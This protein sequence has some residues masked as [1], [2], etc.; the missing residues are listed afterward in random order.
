MITTRPRYSPTAP[1]NSNNTRIANTQWVKTVLA[2]YA[3]LIDP[4]Q[5]I[6][7]GGILIHNGGVDRLI[8]GVDDSNLFYNGNPIV[9]SGLGA[10]PTFGG[11]SFTGTTNPG[12][13]LKSLST[14][15]ITALGAIGNGSIL[16]NSTTDKLLVRLNGVTENIVT[17]LNGVSPTVPSGGTTGQI[18]SK[19]DSTD[20]N[21]QWVTPTGGGTWGSI[22]GTLSS[23]TDLQAALNS[24]TTQFAITDSKGTNRFNVYSGIGD[25]EGFAQF[26]FAS[27]N[28][29]ESLPQI[30]LDCNAEIGFQLAVGSVSSILCYE[31]QIN[32]N[33]ENAMLSLEDS[34]ITLQSGASI[35]LATTDTSIDLN[36]SGFYL[37]VLGY[38]LSINET[39]YFVSDQE[40][41]RTAISAQESINVI[42][43][44]GQQTFK[45]YFASDDRDRLLRLEFISSG[46]SD[47]FAQ[48]AMSINCEGGFDVQ[49]ADAFIS[50]DETELRIG[51]A[52]RFI[53]IGSTG[54]VVSEPEA[55]RTAISAQ[56]TFNVTNAAG[57]QI[58]N[59]LSGGSGDASLFF[60]STDSVNGY[61]SIDV[62]CDSEEGFVVTQSDALLQVNG[63][64]VSIGFGPYTL[65]SNETGYFVSDPAAF[66]QA[67]SAVETFVASDANGTNS[68][69]VVSDPNSYSYLVFQ[70]AATVL[71]GE[72]FP[73]IT[74]SIDCETGFAVAQGSSLLRIGEL[75]VQLSGL[76]IELDATD[77]I[78][79]NADGF[80]EA[81][82][83][84]E[85]LVSGTNIKTINGESILGSGN[86]AVS[87]GGGGGATIND[88][89]YLALAL[90]GP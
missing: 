52:E 4:T 59:V 26:A 41:F 81:I 33:I 50:V 25:S 22:T 77:Y 72:S 47:D 63:T 44:E 32:L 38:G 20:H 7:V 86:I 64:Y 39:G 56:E 46:E 16:V 79:N 9:L 85:T 90:G 82:N 83:A 42:N 11:L 67:I 8:E 14:T 43:D 21:T 17:T 31:N 61:A 40:A 89:A 12:L 23:Q 58:F 19:I 37:D 10:A 24:K 36:A 78:V 80:R 1:S 3:L 57:N 35:L 6:T 29:D 2:D 69:Q 15:Q 76:Q 34:S 73:T 70:S 28:T 62:A 74:M 5:F 45:A 88:I 66:R 30:T 68:F 71:S 53:E 55:F 18:L 27:S 54:W 13:R 65:G 60:R 84:Q 87:G 75:G 48:I 49:H 51:Y